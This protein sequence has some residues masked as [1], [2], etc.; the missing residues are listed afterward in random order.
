MGAGT[1]RSLPES[2]KYS[3]IAN[4]RAVVYLLDVYT[5]N[6]LLL[7]D[8]GAFNNAGGAVRQGRCAG[9]IH[10]NL[11]AFSDVSR[12]YAKPRILIH[13]TYDSCRCYLSR[14]RKS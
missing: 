6:P 9:K 12:S 8:G 4:R 3:Q 13:V 5:Y 7:P 10:C 11:H 14:R 2:V 1:T